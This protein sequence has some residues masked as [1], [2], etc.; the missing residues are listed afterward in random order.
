[1]GSFDSFAGQYFAGVWD[2]SKCILS[3]TETEQLIQP[4]WTRWTATDWG[5]AHHA[6]HLWFTSGK[7]SPEVFASLFGGS[8]E[9]PIDVVV[10]YREL[11]VNETAE[12]D[13]ATMMVERTPGDERKFIQREFL[14]PDAWAKRGSANTVAEQF[15]DAF[16]RHACQ[17]RNQPMTTASG[18]GAWCTTDSGRLA[19]CAARPWMSS[20]PSRARYCSSAQIVLK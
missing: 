17:V 3:M 18:A 16:R 7:L 19:H 13:L 10:V 11:V 15:E 9:W 20:A 6:V 12:G 1:M 5:F 4:W 8:S 2:E 14:S